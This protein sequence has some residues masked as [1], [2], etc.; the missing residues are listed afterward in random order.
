MPKISEEEK[1]RN[2]EQTLMLIRRHN[3]LREV[4]IADILH[5]GR[6]TVNNYLKE[7]EYEGKIY[8]EGL[9]WLATAGAG[10]WLRRFEMAADEA[11]TL[12]LAARQFV[13]HSDKQ[14]PMALSA[15]SR[16]AEVLKTDLPV[17]AEIFRAAQDLRKRKKSS[18]YEN[19][20]AAVV[21]AYLLRHPLQLTYRTAAGHTVNTVFKT[22]L[23]EPSAIGYT[24][25]LIGHSANVD[26]LRSYKIERIQAAVPI[27]DQIYTIPDDFP[28]LDILRN[29]WSI[30]LGEKTER[31]E[32]LFS[33]NVK[34]RVLETNWHPSQDFSDDEPDG[35][36]RW[37]VEIAHTTDIQ[38]WIRGWGTDV[39]VVAPEHLRQHLI[40]TVERLGETYAVRPP[41]ERQP[42]H[43][44]YA[45]TNPDDRGAIHLLLYH[46]IDVGQVAQVLWDE[47]LT[48]SIRQRLAAMLD[49]SEAD[50][51]RFLAFL[52]ALHD[53]G[54]AGPAYQDKY[55]PGWLR[56]KLAQ[57]GLILGKPTD[58]KAYDKA[59]PHGGVTAWALERLLPDAL[60]LEPH[61]AKKIAAALG[62][63]HGVWQAHPPRLDDSQHPA[64]ETA[65]RELLWQVRGTFNPPQGVAA[66][67][68]TTE[69]NTFLTILSGLTSVADWVG[70]RNKE[71][72][73]FVQRVIPTR[74][75]AQTARGHAY[76]EL[77]ELKWIG[78]QP[79]GETQT[80]AE[81]FA[82][83][84]FTAPRETQQ[85]VI[86]LA[87]DL[88]P[89]TLLILEAPTGL[90][91]TE[92]ALY[93]ADTWLQTHRGRGLYIAMPTTATSNQMYARVGKFLA[94]RYPVDQIN[95]HL[96]HGQAAWADDLKK[97]VELQSVGDDTAARLHA[98]SWFTPRKR[99]LLAPFGV[100]TVDQTLMSILQTKHFFVR[101]FGLAHKV[102]I[103]DEVHAYDTYMNTLFHRLLAWL[104]AIG[105]SVI[106]LSAT[107]PAKTRRELVDAYAGERDRLKPTPENQSALKR[108]NLEAGQPVSTGF[109]S[110][111][112]DSSAGVD[113]EEANLYP[114]LTI[115]NAARR[116]TLPLP[117]P[118]EDGYTLELDW[119][120]GRDPGEIAA[121]LERELAGGGC[122]AVICNTVRRAQD[123]YRAVQGAG[124]VPADDLILFHSRFPPVWRKEIEAKVLRKFGKPGEDGQS[125]R[126][127]KA[128]VV[129]TQVIEQSLDID[130]D[131]MVTDLAPVD[132][133]LQRAGRL[134][135][136]RDNP[137]YG[138][139]RRLVI[140]PPLKDDFGIP[141]FQ[142]NRD[143]YEPY[144]L[145]QSFITL[146]GVT[147]IKLPLEMTKYIEAVYQEKNT[148]HPDPHWKN[149]LERK[150]DEM[151]S[152]EHEAWFK[153]QSQTVLSVDDEELLESDNI[154]LDEDD[155]GTQK[156]FRAMTRDIPPG[157]NLVCLH[158]RDGKLYLD[159][160]GKSDE[161]NLQVQPSHKQAIAL[162]MRT[163]TVHH[164][165]VFNYFLDDKVPEGWK[166]HP[167]LKYCRV[168]IFTNCECKLVGTK[169]RMILTRNLGLEIV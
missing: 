149:E 26:A 144:I 140:V 50:T 111:P 19:I 117:F 23:I 100:G 59:T 42:Y 163:L 136:H 52:T 36:L 35:R 155:P 44:L 109:A 97:Q 160:E 53:L 131:L 74:E 124:F 12:Y 84:D 56:E 150:Y 67:S 167:V 9:N 11:F 148:E 72:F 21:K 164:P 55:A 57:S 121:F 132:L 133:I 115:A 22:Y 28:G 154:Q 151:R 94:E 89:P 64:W 157:I 24:L 90:G 107:L 139:A 66:P 34:D 99:T 46:L 51:G 123:V 82:Y 49:L 10:S 147:E 110:Q 41:L 43:W 6:R 128:I 65:R 13:K 102:V 87:R 2:K 73:G 37:W 1:Q 25:Y 161:Y 126:P 39:E 15:L 118:A 152:N 71:R 120:A 92:T 45:K 93:L 69:L 60:G 119:G 91:K 116:E 168:A 68:D 27:Y 156:N 108:P 79:S 17:S 142:R 16:L 165:I 127:Q 130:F 83:L 20:F 7:L 40:H 78:W 76:E 3:G 47:V 58:G 145:L 5:L 104:N 122:A 95:Y 113:D 159:P 112:A 33:K 48:G 31:V 63:H 158:R 85:A 166:N 14:N 75:Y 18:D 32:L 62:G 8:K 146:D 61:F 153:A 38:P 30:M 162:Q 105:T 101:L 137:R 98:E 77:T 125:H 29:A 70:S 88:V 106:L 96:V 86:D 114:A 80:F 169:C 135:R 143:I 4:E 138:L 141:Q 134:H 103:F 81:L 129:A 54:K